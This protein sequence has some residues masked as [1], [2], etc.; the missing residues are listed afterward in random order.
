MNEQPET[1]N[2]LAKFVGILLIVVFI[3]SMVWSVIFETLLPMWRAEQILEMRLNIFGIPFIFS[4]AGVFIY[5]G[6]IFVRGTLNALW[7]DEM[8][9]ERAKISAAPRDSNTARWQTLWLLFNGW[10]RGLLWLGVGFGL[11]VIGSVLINAI[12]IFGL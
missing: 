5:G 6:L 7:S 2:G 3:G 9:A 4:G 12:K 1:G 10:K 11:I 8:I